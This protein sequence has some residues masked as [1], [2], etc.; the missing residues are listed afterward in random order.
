[1][2]T[3]LGEIGNLPRNP[4]VRPAIFNNDLALFKNFRWGERR[5]I[6]LRW[7][8]YNLFNHTNYSDIDSGLVFGLQQ[9]NPSPTGAACSATNVCTAVFRQTDPNFG[10]PTTARSPRVMQASIRINF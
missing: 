7:E 2:P 6:Q 8:T 4:I 5:Q 3:R 9:V 1:M 10:T